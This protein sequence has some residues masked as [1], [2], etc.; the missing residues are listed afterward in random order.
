[1]NQVLK[2]CVYS[3]GTDEQVD[4]VAKMGGMNDTEKKIFKK[5]HQGEKDLEIQMDMNMS[6]NTHETF[7]T[8]V[9]LKVAVAVLQCIDR[10]MNN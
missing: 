10:C 4:F 8:S 3:L 6:D 1:M 7:E 5:M 9:R 2:R